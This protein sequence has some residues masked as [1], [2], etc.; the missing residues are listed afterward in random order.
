MKEK[1]SEMDRARF[2][3]LVGA[4]GADFARW[5][6]AERQAGEAFADAHPDEVSALLAEARRLDALLAYAR[7][8]TPN[9][10]ALSA[11][12]LVGAPQSLQGFGVGARWALAACALLGVVAGYGGGLLAP[13]AGDADDSYFAMAF[14]APAPGDEG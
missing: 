7:G 9:V 12:I 13:P 14:E 8:D 1:E 3:H 5:P 11:R 6:A 2:E 4:Y 10:T